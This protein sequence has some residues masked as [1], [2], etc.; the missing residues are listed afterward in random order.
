MAHLA[1]EKIDGR[2][3]EG[4]KVGSGADVAGEDD[5]FAGKGDVEEEGLEVI[6]AK[7]GAVLIE[8]GRG[9]GG[10]GDVLK[11]AR[12]ARFPRKAVDGKTDDAGNEEDG[13]KPILKW[14][15]EVPGQADGQGIGTAVAVA[16]LKKHGEAAN[17]VGVGMGDPDGIDVRE[18]EAEIEQLSGAGLT[19]IEEDICGIGL[20]EDACLEA[21]GT[22]IAGAGS[23]KSHAGH[24]VEVE[25]RGGVGKP[26]AEKVAPP[27]GRP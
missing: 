21:S 18:G 25:F 5:S 24:G 27:G 16:G 19:G 20:K 9:M 1:D 11:G 2:S 3:Q 13:T 6:A 12:D 22:T 10:N 7:A 17:V 8:V 4:L 26:G 15:D 23:Q 14:R